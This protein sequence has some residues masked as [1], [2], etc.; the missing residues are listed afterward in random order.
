MALDLEALDVKIALD[1]R[2]FVLQRCSLYTIN[3]TEALNQRPHLVSRIPLL[4]FQIKGLDIV[5]L[6]QDARF[7]LLRALMYRFYMML[8]MM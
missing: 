6:S 4:R 2:A 3:K 5:K 7:F 8:I 1:F